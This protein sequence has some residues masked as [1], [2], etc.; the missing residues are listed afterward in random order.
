[1]LNKSLKSSIH[2]TN[3]ASWHVEAV[4]QSSVIS[5]SL[6]EVTVGQ[7]VVHNSVFK[8]GKVSI[9]LLGSKQYP[10]NQMLRKVKGSLQSFSC[11]PKP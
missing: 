10:F 7:D 11:P 4:A 8:F 5:G 1:M 9:N 3:K 6:N 2:L